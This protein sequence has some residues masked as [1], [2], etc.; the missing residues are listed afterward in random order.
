MKLSKI[1][2]NIVIWTSFLKL[3]SKQF[4]LFSF[5]VLGIIC[6]ACAAPA[7]TI[8]PSFFGLGHNHFFLFIVVTTFIITLVWTFFYL[9]QVKDTIKVRNQK[10]G[11]SKCWASLLSGET[12]VHLH[13]AGGD[14]H[15]AGDGL[16]HRRLDRGALRVWLVHHKPQEK[17][18][19][20]WRQGGSRGECVCSVL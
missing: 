14:L 8:D 15:L 3:L 18:H 2:P 10:S 9:L 16:L 19:H 17:Q 1:I 6:M 13:E 20:L 4:W 7:Q 5:Q 11:K 12:A